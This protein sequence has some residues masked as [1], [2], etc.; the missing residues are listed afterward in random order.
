MLSS[1]SILQ[2]HIQSLPYQNSISPLYQ[3]ATA[4]MSYCYSFCDENF[5]SF[6]KIQKT[7]NFCK[8]FSVT[9]QI[10]YNFVC[11][12]LWY[13]SYYHKIQIWSCF[14]K[15]SISSRIRH[16]TLEI[17]FKRLST[18]NHLHPDHHL[19]FLSF[20]WTYTDVSQLSLTLIYT[21]PQ[22]SA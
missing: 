22:G 4:L 19:E 14:Q 2:T 21:S 6:F 8:L 20:L 17:I 18:L 12:C 13:C 1:H 11:I 9:L 7:H 3:Y 5:Y 10:A 15:V 16:T